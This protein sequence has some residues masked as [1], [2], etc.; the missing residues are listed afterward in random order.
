M[1]EIFVKDAL[2]FWSEQ[3][4]PVAQEEA[5]QQARLLLCHV[6][7]CEAGEL[8]LLREK[9]LTSAQAAQMEAMCKRRLNN[10]PLQYI[11]G[12]WAFMGLP[13][14]V[15]EGALIPRQDTETLCE[16]ALCLARERGYK[17][18]LD[19]GCGTG[20]IGV[21]LAKLGG[22]QVT[23]VDCMQACVALTKENAARNGVTLD[24]REGDYASSIEGR[25][26]MI[27]SNPP[28]LTKAELINC[29]PELRY[30]PA[31]A[32][33]GGEDGLDAYRAIAAVYHM[34]L[35]AG[36][37][38]LL[39]VG[40]TQADAVSALFRGRQVE[41]VKDINGISRVVCVYTKPQQKEEE[42]KNYAQ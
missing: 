4:Y 16:K 3:L 33:D 26:D 12:E 36:G 28:Y 38:L 20:C 14:Y 6:L 15:R 27:V 1:K 7:C 40:A 19:I 29:Q 35:H 8:P 25:F 42:I 24:V 10:A 11:L 9:T 32:L 21:A 5:A 23:A 17:T 2:R 31:V 30:E 37:A 34:H 39:E 41:I 18:A 13:F 22:L